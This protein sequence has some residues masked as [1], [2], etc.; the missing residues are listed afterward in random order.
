[1]TD[2]AVNRIVALVFLGIVVAPVLVI[3]V[4]Q[5][6]RF[7]PGSVAV[8]RVTAQYDIRPDGG[9]D[10]TETIDYDYGESGR[11]LDRVVQLRRPDD[12]GLDASVDDRGTDRVWEVSDIAATD[13][14]GNP[15]PRRTKELDPNLPPLTSTG[16]DGW[17][18]RLSDLRIQLGER[19]PYLP[20][21]R[22]ETTFILK[23]RVHGALDE[24]PGG[25]EL[26]WPT[27]RWMPAVTPPS[28]CWSRWPRLGGERFQLT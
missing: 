17:D 10:V 4:E 19:L 8:T 5:T 23:Y 28:A 1:M 22:R 15:V 25:Y 13:P 14:D 2:G 6:P 21:A 26:K 12:A 18:T 3:V 24:V 7:Y 11:P 9:L 16:I 20:G 27:L